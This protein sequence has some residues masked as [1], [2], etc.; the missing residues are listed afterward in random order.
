[1]RR[2]SDYG[3][4]QQ[5]PSCAYISALSIGHLWRTGP[6]PYDVQLAR[7]AV[8]LVRRRGGDVLGWSYRVWLPVGITAPPYSGVK[9]PR[10]E[11]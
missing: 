6:T 5:E 7:V 4:T 11:D 1:M 8:R 9:F 2:L 3:D 10:V